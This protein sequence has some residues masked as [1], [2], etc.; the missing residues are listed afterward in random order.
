MDLSVTPDGT[1]TVDFPNLVMA[2]GNG[3]FDDNPE[4]LAFACAAVKNAFE[5]VMEMTFSSDSVE[6]IRQICGLMAA[7]IESGALPD[8]RS[9]DFDPEAAQAASANFFL[10]GS[11]T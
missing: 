8:P 4:H 11:R 10:R 1:V 3:Q 5:T 6:H 2:V 7:A 9:E